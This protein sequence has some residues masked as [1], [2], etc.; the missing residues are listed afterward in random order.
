VTPGPVASAREEPPPPDDAD[1][2]A[3]AAGD[4]PAPPR[5]SALSHEQRAALEARVRADAKSHPRVQ[6]VIEAL[7]AELREIRVERPSEKRGELA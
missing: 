4:E 6:Q 1:L 3:F 2:A 5:A 7:D